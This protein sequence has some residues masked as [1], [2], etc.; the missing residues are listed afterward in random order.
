MDTVLLLTAGALAAVL[1]YRLVMR[2]MLRRVL[3]IVLDA[4][5]RN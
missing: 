1:A 3:K 4:L 5:T 2:W